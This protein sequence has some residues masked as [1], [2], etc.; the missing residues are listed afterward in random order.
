MTRQ[1]FIKLC[2]LFGISL[3]FQS[4]LAS[5]KSDDINNT[6][7]FNG[8][9]L[10]IGAGAAGLSAGYLLQQRGIDFRILE[11]AP[12]YGGRMKRTTDFADFPIPLGAEWLHMEE[13][14]FNEIVNDSSI[15]IDVNTTLYDPDNDFTLYDG[16]LISLGEDGFTIDQKFIN[17]TW[18]D[19]FDEYIVPSV[20]N[21]ILFNTIVESIDYSENQVMVNTSGT[22]F[23]AD[24]VI[25]AVPVKQLQNNAITF[26]PQLPSKKRNAINN[27]TVWD[28]FKA[29]IEFSDQFYPTFIAYDILPESAG[30]KLY[31]D[32]AYG[33]NTNQ[34][35][36]GLFT[37]GAGTLPYRELEDNQLIEYILNELDGLFN[38]QA[39]ATYIK[40]ISQNWNN[41]P[42][43]NGAYIMDQENWRRVRTLGES[44]NDKLYFAGDAYT[45]GEDWSSVHTA[46]RSAKQ[47]VDNLL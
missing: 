34:H 44:V 6:T 30:Q 17:S 15:S 16:E 13:G 26:T 38:G 37:V 7:N 19:F 46:A 8:N 43:I 36:L 5:C 23:S 10:I 9:V 28:G 3:P 20:E 2:S 25:V 32:A 39:S 45:D 31:Y 33:Q 21:K 42:Y 41:E 40:H 4:V 18:F 27:V 14:I 1:D 29:F 35:I 12:T 22:S 47:A 11:A 24:K